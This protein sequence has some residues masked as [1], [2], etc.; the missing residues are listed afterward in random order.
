MS[1]RLRFVLLYGSLFSSVLLLVIVLSYAFHA[2]SHYDEIDRALVSSTGHITAQALLSSAETHWV[3]ES[4]ELGIALR[5]YSTDGTVRGSP[6]T[7]ARLPTLDPTAILARPAGP[8]FD[9]LAGLVPPLMGAPPLPDAG[10]FGLAS[11][12]EQRWR[13][14]VTPLSLDGKASGYVEALAPLGRLD[15]SLNRLRNLLLGL[16]AAGLLAG[17]VGSWAVAGQALQ[18]VAQMIQTASKITLDHDFSHRIALPASKDELGHLAATFNEMLASLEETYQAQRRFVADASHELRA[19]LSVIQG[20]LELLRS[21]QMSASD[22]KESLA[23]AEREATRL[24]RLVGDLLA[25]AR[26]DAGGTLDQKVVDLDAVVLEALS[27]AHSLGRGHTIALGAFEP[28]QVSGDKDR[29]KQLLLILLDNALK[30]TPPDGRVVVELKCGAAEAEITIRDTGIGIPSESLPHVFERFY[31]ADP[32][33]TRDPGGT[34]LGLSIAKWIVDQHRGQITILS[35]LQHGTT[36]RVSFP[37]TAKDN[38]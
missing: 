25:L 9:T 38:L 31:R 34:G 23:E 20:N 1:I 7:E 36:A 5:L 28:V 2:R 33:R 32:A 24:T 10:A 8:A 30:Y 26:A 12:P 14:Y 37:L 19:P 29:L 22:R 15:E 11:T 3:G 21:R 35:E 13:I 16:G 27:A 18:P 4:E 6:S 17:L